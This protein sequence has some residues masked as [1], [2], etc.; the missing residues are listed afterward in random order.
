MS[1]LKVNDEFDE[2]VDLFWLGGDKIGTFS[3]MECDQHGTE[4]CY[5]DVSGSDHCIECIKE[6]C[7]PKVEY[8]MPGFEN[9][10]E[11]LEKLTIRTT[12]PKDTL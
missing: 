3:R 8:T 12:P 6:M 10:E 2:M 7:E 4:W 5:T 1:E 9:I 11:D